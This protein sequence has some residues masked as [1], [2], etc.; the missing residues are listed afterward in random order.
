MNAAESALL[1]CSDDF[2]MHSFRYKTSFFLTSVTQLCVQ[3]IV[4]TVSLQW[5]VVALI[6]NRFFLLL[7]RLYSF[8]GTNFNTS[9]ASP[10]ADYSSYSCASTRVSKVLIYFICWATTEIFDNVLINCHSI[11]QY[12]VSLFNELT[13]TRL[14][15]FL[16][17]FIHM[18][19]AVARDLCGIVV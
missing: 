19:F 9:T 17:C 15:K 10:I 8:L 18:S 7:F 14:W 4:N 12:I 13:Y 2:W 16:F 11:S 6:P 5:P 1:W 3:R